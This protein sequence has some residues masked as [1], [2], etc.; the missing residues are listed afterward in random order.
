MKGKRIAFTLL[1]ILCVCMI[2]LFSH[3][4]GIKSESISDGF[5]IKLIEVYSKITKKEILEERKEELVIIMRNFVRKSAH[6]TIYLLLGIF[7]YGSL[8]SYGVK[9]AF[10]Y[11]ILFCFLYACTDE[12]HQLFVSDRTGR[13][14]DVFLDTCGAFVGSSFFN[15][16]KTDKKCHLLSKK[17]LTL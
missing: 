5:T 12:V 1:V 6:F 17:S 3:Q 9:H 7:V 8:L 11:S 4:N 15:L 2:F 16:F 13:V 14:F 10:I